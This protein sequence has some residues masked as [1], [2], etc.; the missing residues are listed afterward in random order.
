LSVFYVRLV[1][2]RVDWQTAC[3]MLHGSIFLAM[4]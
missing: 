3:R 2:L 4:A 1:S